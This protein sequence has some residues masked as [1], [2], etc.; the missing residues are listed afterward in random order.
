MNTPDGFLDLADQCRQHGKSFSQGEKC[1]HISYASIEN[2][3]GWKI[4][5]Y[6]GRKVFASIFYD[7]VKKVY[8]AVDRD[9]N[10]LKYNCQENVKKHAAQFFMKDVYKNLTT[11]D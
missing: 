6:Y 3:T 1:I 11:L 10:I 4:S 7:E 9:N 5:D 8:F 2:Q